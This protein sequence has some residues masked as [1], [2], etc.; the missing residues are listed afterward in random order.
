[1]NEPPHY[2]PEI[3]YEKRYAVCWY[4]QLAGKK[5]KKRVSPARKETLLN[6]IVQLH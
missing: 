4:I 1:M 3:V 2:R 6:I 5:R